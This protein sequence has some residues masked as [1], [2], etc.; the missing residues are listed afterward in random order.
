LTTV[1]VTGATDGL[2]RGVAQALARAGATVLLHGRSAERLRATADELERATSRRPRTLR[3]DLA[4]LGEVRALAAEVRDSVPRLDVLVNNAGIGPGQPDLPTRQ[5]SRDGHE[6]RFAVNHLA[7]FA[8][9]LE[10]LELLRA[11][12]PARVVHVASA[13]QAPVDLEDPMLVAAYSPEAAY[14]ASKLAQ[15]ACAL[16]LARR[17]PAAEVSVISLHPGTYLPTKIVL[18]ALHGTGD[19][20]DGGVAAVVRLATEPRLRGVTGRYFDRL[21]PAAPHPQATDPEAR[22][23]LWDLSIALTGAPP[24]RPRERPA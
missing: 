15:V 10:L 17:V 18:D 9:T 11:S 7:S 12:A 13:A 24:P 22:R 1:L 6:L 16:E 19:P 4:S 20:L 14:C 2:G 21:A 5:E 8:L 3:A 23:R